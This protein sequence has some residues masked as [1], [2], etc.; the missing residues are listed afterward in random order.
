MF[1]KLR[2]AALGLL[3]VVPVVGGI[4]G[5]KAL[6]FRAM[7]EAS[8]RMVVPPE[9]VNVA[10]VREEEWHPRVSS[11]GTVTAVQGTI[12][13]TEAEGVVREI[14]FEPGSTVKAGEEL[15]QLDIE[16]E[17][18]QLR[19]AE[20]SAELARLSFVRAKELVTSHSISTA[21]FDA[22]EATLKQSNAQVDNI[23]AQIAKKT[24]RAPFG[25]KLGIQNISLGQ[26]LERG[27]AVVSLQSLDPVHVDFSVP[28]QRLG[29]LSEGL[30]V[31]VVT[32]SYPGERFEGTITAVNPE[33]DASTRNVRVQAT[34]ANGDGRL[35]PGVYVTV[36]VILA[37]STKELF[38]PASAV[39]HAPFGDSV[40][41]VEE[42][43]AG[44]DGKKPLVAGQ[45]F[46][47]LGE[48]QGD[49]VVAREGVKRGEK[50]VSTGVFKLRPGVPVVV[51]TT[52]AP[53]FS[54]TPRP[55]NS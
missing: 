25:G 51:D 37:A 44:P 55:P 34:M 49:Y 18:A 2:W 10:E 40:F 41:V 16:V 11:V 35:R 9:K 15:A 45:R 33:V 24:V 31:E 8:A 54:F 42:G 39:H 50:I 1:T 38:I 17:A 30:K 22:A 29:D 48:H 43:E 19:S 21:E 26:Y 6:Q 13:R 36:D 12:V 3:I 46:V 5:V 53:E 27:S 28:Q 52:L 32:D 23:R 7:G 14:K 47:R 20:A 4:V